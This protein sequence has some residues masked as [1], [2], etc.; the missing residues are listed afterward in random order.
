MKKYLVGL[1]VLSLVLSVFVGFDSI[2]FAQK[3][4]NEAPMLT[5]LVKAGKLPPIEER[6]PEDPLVVGPGVL[7][8]KGDL[9]FEIGQY[10]GTM[11]LVHDQPD[12]ELSVFIQCNEPL[13]S[14]PGLNAADADIKGN[15][16]KDWSVSSD[17]KTFTF[18]MRKG[19][20]WS[21]GEPVTTE[22]VRFA[23]EDFLLNEKLTPVFPTYLRSGNRPDGKPMK[24]EILDKY[25]FRIRFDE[26]YGGFPT[27]LAING[28]RSYTDLIKP[29]HYLK[30]FHI[31]YTPLEKLKPL[32]EKEK[33]KDEWWQL[34]NL[35][36]H[37]IWEIAQSSAVGFPFL[38][39]WIPVQITMG[40]KVFE[41]N[42]YYF[43]VDPEGNQL[44]YIDRLS[45]VLVSNAET[46][47]LKVIAGEVDHS[48]E[49][50]IFRNM[51]LYKANAA[52]GDYRIILYDLHRTTAD[53]VLNLTYPD[54]AWRK[55][56]RDIRF[57]KALNMAINR[58]ELIET[59]YYG[60]A[61]LPTSVP[62]EYNPQKA[63]QLLDDMGLNKRDAEGWRL[64]P[65]GKRFVIPIE[66]F[67]HF[68]EITTTA[69]L[70]AEYWKKIGIMTT[71][72]TLEINLWG[73]RNAAN[74]LKATFY[75]WT[76][77]SRLWWA[78]WTSGAGYWGP[79]W[80]IWMTTGGKSGEEPPE[81]V[82][83]YYNVI[84]KL[85]LVPPNQ[86]PK[87]H[88]EFIRL[89]YNNLWW[90]ITVEDLKYP[91]IVSNRLGN[92]AHKGYGIAAQFAGEIYYFKK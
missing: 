7:L 83:R 77:D 29:K 44:P 86:R 73:Q 68:E 36:D 39:P 91:V 74:D 84:S 33:L 48:Y 69:Q 78:L 67:P 16:L 37:T 8:P 87:I 53:P 51:P 38:T 82:K 1:V 35:K 46:A 24:L 56:V 22:D 45:S 12:T 4:Y 64:G 17:W 21:D 72:K 28:W 6:L 3:K 20:K 5:E 80:D 79:L 40:N 92:V 65:D 32:L 49:Y 13:L 61:S 66:Y 31:K 55:V 25:T 70:I 62:S 52:K 42:P 89:V 59:V 81:E 57:R 54:P 30:Q 11:R 18:H 75:L 71:T 14:G 9:D 90:F 10:G 76:H 43:K 47:N 85:Y 15:V 2:S 19:L 60:F 23:Y 50:G 58:K 63:N 27:Q 41:R 88:D 26:P 34:F